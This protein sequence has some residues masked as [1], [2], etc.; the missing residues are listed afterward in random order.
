V[1][2]YLYFA[3]LF[4]SAL[5]LFSVQPMV[6]KMVLPLLGG[7]PAIWNT[8]V[9]FFQA[10]L[11][12]GY[13]YVH[14][15][16]RLVGFRAQALIHLALL[17]LALAALPVAIAPGWSDPGEATPVLWLIGLLVVSVGAPLFIVS[18]TAPLLQ[19]WFAHTG[20]RTAADPYFLYAASNLGSLLALLSYPV[21][22]EP[23]IG[24]A[25]QGRLWSWGYAALIGLIGMTVLAAW[26][27]PDAAGPRGAPS[28][29]H[30]LVDAIDWRQ[31]VH[32]LLL[33]FAPVSLFLG[34]TLHIST[35][36]AAT[37][38]LWVAP[39]AVYLL[40]FVLVF[41]R[42]PILKHQW[43]LQAQVF[44]LIPLAVYFWVDTLWL[45]FLVH[46]GGLF[47]TAMVCHGELIR[48]R[49][50]TRHLTEFYLL[51]S[52]GGLLGGVLSAIVAPVVFDTAVEYP[53]ALVLACA[54][55]P[56]LSRGGIRA[57]VADLAVPAGLAVATA[58]PFLEPELNP[59][60]LGEPGRLVFFG[61]VAAVLY[62]SR[63]RPMRFALAIAGVL[64]GPHLVADSG[65]VL[66]QE[67]SFF[68]VY[69]VQGLEPGPLHLLRHGTTTHG[70]ELLA[71]GFSR[72]PLSYYGRD[73]PL[74][75]V[76][77]AL[78]RQ[79]AVRRIGAVGLGIG[80]VACYLRPGQT[81]DFFEID[82]IIERLARD[83]R[84]FRYLA[85][86]GEKVRIRIGDGRLALSAE[87]D[88]RYDLIVLDA[89]SSDAIPVH[90]LT[91]E[92][93]ALYIA[94]LAEGGVLA[95]HISNNFVDL[96]PVLAALVAEAGLIARVQEFSP[97]GAVMVNGVDLS[98]ALF[99]SV[100]VVV[101]RAPVDL[102][103]LFED[104][105]W[106]ALGTAAGI[107][108]WTDDYSNV[109]ETL[110]WTRGYDRERQ[111]R[112]PEPVD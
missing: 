11:L 72:E 75:Q 24:L 48:R 41:A 4:L 51:M 79:Q 40:S 19:S 103:G 73:G 52:L 54:L 64:A 44:V 102:E 63:L 100:W 30:R 95:F 59:S 86:C 62:W 68:G 78:N 25:R 31:R 49:P 15:T 12:A 2:L 57:A 34:V 35:D 20:H 50:T 76:I 110:I 92:A 61:A 42:R 82:P 43:M 99:E 96:R 13:L 58:L 85:E 7:S 71:A 98:P 14:L 77:A 89:F 1:S 21:L 10:N 6:T 88:G 69:R 53:L 74:G 93:L 84:L 37:P 65:S 112:G 29:R 66:A 45:V 47:V 26:R 70:V 55:R 107:R 109:F 87:P 9:V 46:L 36:V 90:L 60:R 104:T 8:A 111:G 27:R 94:K 22:V 83:P 106:R 5:L 56:W 67:R 3:A 101:G 91:R 17:A 32:W 108:P 16:T 80:T 23:T 33:S 38:F 18:A 105:R 39:L 28:E 81:A 97:K